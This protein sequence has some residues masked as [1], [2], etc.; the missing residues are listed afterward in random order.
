MVSSNNL[1]T[2][3][4]ISLKKYNSYDKLNI[5]TKLFTSEVDKQLEELILLFLLFS[6]FFSW[7]G[8]I[9]YLFVF[10]FI[11]PWFSYEWMSKI[12][13]FCLFNLMEMVWGQNCIKWFLNSPKIQLEYC[14]QIFQ[15]LNMGPPTLLINIAMVN[16]FVKKTFLE[17]FQRSK[18]YSEKSWKRPTKNNKW[19]VRQMMY[20]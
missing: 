7:G 4:T 5:T 15:I 11:L 14:S 9:F 8:W 2:G 16:L 20:Q 10:V 19:K 3:N 6:F 13:I 12:S 18:C 17:L 1:I